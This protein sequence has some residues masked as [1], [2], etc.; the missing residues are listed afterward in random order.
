MTLFLPRVPGQPGLGREQAG[1][2]AGLAAVPFQTNM[3]GT[4]EVRLS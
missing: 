4:E 3:Y 1:S 2:C